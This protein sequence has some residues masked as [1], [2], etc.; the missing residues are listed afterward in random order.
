MLMLC[1]RDNS[2]PSHS[3]LCCSMFSIMA[4]RA[5]T[6][7]MISFSSSVSSS[8]GAPPDTFIV[9]LILSANTQTHTAYKVACKVKNA[10]QTISL[11]KTQK[12]TAK[13]VWTL[14]STDRST[15][16]NWASAKKKCHTAANTN[17][18]T[19][20]ERRRVS[21]RAFCAAERHKYMWDWC[22]VTGENKEI[23]GRCGVHCCSEGTEQTLTFTKFWAG[24]GR[25]VSA[26]W[27]AGSVW[28]YKCF[29]LSFQKQPLAFKIT[30]GRPTEQR[31]DFIAS[32]NQMPSACE[33]ESRMLLLLL[34]SS[35]LGVSVWW[36]CGRL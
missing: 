33:A 16:G 35:P 25:V 29:W 11:K 15:A 14:R 20:P 28:S 12:C 27:S 2:F 9:L 17:T 18:T 4:A 23:K 26:R 8:P 3:I 13:E 21:R 34:L 6:L 10:A 7:L 31:P 36:S 32:E 30:C 1:N 5:S 24:V 22:Y 19:S